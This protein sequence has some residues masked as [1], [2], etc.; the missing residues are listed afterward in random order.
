MTNKTKSNIVELRAPRS[1]R[2]FELTV[3]QRSPATIF[4]FDVAQN[5]YADTDLQRLW[6]V[7]QAAVAFEKGGNKRSKPKAR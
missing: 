1:R 7:W 6:E 4:N 3:E 5:K 2:A